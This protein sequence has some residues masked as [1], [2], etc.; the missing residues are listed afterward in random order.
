MQDLRGYAV[1]GA[2]A[3]SL[4]LFETALAQ[5]QC[6]VVDPVATIDKAIIS[7]PS[8]V[9]AHLLRAYLLLAGTEAAYLPMARDGRNATAVLPTNA[10][11]R[12]FS[13]VRAL[14]GERMALKPASPLNRRYRDG[15][16]SIS[17]AMPLNAA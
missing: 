12:Q 10:R 14:S 17:R 7:S 16:L 4:E 5:F 13:L 6:Y 8:F 1:S 3:A 11:D 15:A 2:D 9:T